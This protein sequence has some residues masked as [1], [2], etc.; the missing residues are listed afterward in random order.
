MN[1]ALI[2]WLCTHTWTDMNITSI[3]ALGGDFARSRE[4][5]TP[6]LGQPMQQRMVK[7]QVV[8]VPPRDPYAALALASLRMA[9]GKSVFFCMRQSDRVV[10]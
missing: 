10:E 7:D 4:T 6:S 5:V 1:N 3:L 2:E 8:F 9:E